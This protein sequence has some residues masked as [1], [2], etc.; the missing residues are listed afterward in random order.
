M[1]HLLNEN[2]SKSRTMQRIM[3]S[4]LVQCMRQSSTAEDLVEDPAKWYPL[5]AADG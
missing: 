3:L 2:S 1:K 5:Y 4:K